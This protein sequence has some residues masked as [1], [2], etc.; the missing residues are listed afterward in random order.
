LRHVH[1]LRQYT[2][3][4]PGA[5]SGS[6]RRDRRTLGKPRRT[7]PRQGDESAIL[8][9]G[10]RQLDRYFNQKLRRFDL[11]LAARGT[12]FQKRVWAMMRDIPYGETATYGGMAMALAS[13][14][15]AIGMACGRN[16]IP[17]IVP[18]HRVLASGGRRRLLVGAACRPSGNCWRSKA[19]CSP[20]P[21]P[22]GRSGA[23][24]PAVS[25]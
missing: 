2:R 5:R 15:R 11:P 7:Q 25:L 14:A 1:L 9:E 20:R 24:S 12:D 3:R 23:F 22:E 8:E 16:P 17:I 13:G 18:F 10:A 4:P 19:W 21:E 6:R